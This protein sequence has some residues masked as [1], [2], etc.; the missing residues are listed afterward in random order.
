MPRRATSSGRSPTSDLPSSRTSPPAIGSRAHDRVQRRRLPGPVRA[1]QADDLARLHLEREPRT[2]STAPYRTDS[3]RPR[4]RVTRPPRR[5][6]LA[7]VGGRDAEVPR[8]SPP[9]CPRRASCPGRARGCA[10]RPRAR[11]RRCGRRAAPRRRG[12]RTA[13]TAAANRGTSASGR[14][15]AG[16]SMSTKRGCVASARATPSRRSS[17]CDRSTPGGPRTSASPSSPSSSFARRRALGGRRSDAERRD[18]DVLPHRQPAEARGCA[19]TC[20]RARAARA[21]APTSASRRV[22]RASIAPAVGRSKPLRMLTSVDLPAPFGPIRPTTSPGASS[23]ETSRSASTP[24]NER[25]TEEARSDASGP[26]SL[27]CADR[28][29]ALRVRAVRDLLGADQALLDRRRCC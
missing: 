9:A 8:G 4:A 13:L 24:A 5:R 10:R 19:G 3:S 29:Q 22:P 12:R 2:A 25:E 7:E 28:R 14:P 18:L 6:A 1:D 27:C 26:P 23:S 21:G 15:A 11:A 17:P 16:S 20:A